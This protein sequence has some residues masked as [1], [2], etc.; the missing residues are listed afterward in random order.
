MMCIAMAMLSSICVKLHSIARS[1]V[2]VIGDIKLKS[3]HIC[4]Y[5][6]LMQYFYMVEISL[7]VFYFSGLALQN[8]CDSM[9]LMII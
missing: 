2:M 7:I 9:Y 3:F 8:S 6:F 5:I 4:L 1:K